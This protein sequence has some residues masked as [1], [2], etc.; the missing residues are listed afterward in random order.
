MIRTGLFVMAIGFVVLIFGI[1]SEGS[2]IPTLLM[3]A[4]FMIIG[5]VM[6][7]RAEKNDKS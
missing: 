3:A 6:H 4:V 7:T 2:R 5:Y 1:V